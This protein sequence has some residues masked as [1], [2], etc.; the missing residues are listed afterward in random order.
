MF[1]GISFFLDGQPGFSQLRIR[2]FFDLD[3]QSCAELCQLDNIFHI[4]A[5][6]RTAAAEEK[7]EDHNLLK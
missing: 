2:S 3:S 5:I 6:L 4:F 1:I 7:Y